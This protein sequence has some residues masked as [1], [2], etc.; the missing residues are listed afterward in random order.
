VTSPP[1]PQRFEPG[2]P[3]PLSPPPGAR[4]TLLPGEHTGALFVE[5][6]LRVDG[7]G[8][9]L[10]A[11]GRGATVH[12]A[13][14][15]GALQL[16]GL[17][18]RGG[19]SELGGCLR[20]DGDMEVAAVGCVIEAGLAGQGGDAVGALRGR[21]RLEGCVVRG[22]VMLTGVVDA[23]LVGCVIEGDLKLREGAELRLV[24]GAVH[25]A[26]DLRGT[27][28][29]APVCSVEGAALGL[30]RNDSRLPGVLRG[31]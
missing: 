10:N 21:L 5:A 18:L 19:R 15:E 7:P 25:G 11:H 17:R 23:E 31:V 24:G 27:T 16:V 26:L 20:L 3:L 12:A 29:R 4:L 8:A 22:E 14:D 2:E 28:T 1:A 9:T 30:V 6:A 13:G